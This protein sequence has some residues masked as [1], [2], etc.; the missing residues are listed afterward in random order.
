MPNETEEPA[1]TKLDR[2]RELNDLLRTTLSEGG[3]L[4]MTRG[5]AVLPPD[6]QLEV[7]KAVVQFT[8]F[9]SDNDPRRE[10]DCAV[11]TAAGHRIIWKIDYYDAGL[12]FLSRDPS[13]PTVT[14]RV[15]TVM[16][17]SEY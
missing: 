16:L 6:D 11:L 1:P 10:H 9:N 15:L 7:L 17:A 2:I 8:D 4:V 5:I 3:R 12:K 14:R 13:N